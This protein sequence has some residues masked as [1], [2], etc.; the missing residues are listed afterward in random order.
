MYHLIYFRF[1][2]FM[3]G[4]EVGSLEVSYIGGKSYW[5]RKPLILDYAE[6]FCYVSY[7]I[8]KV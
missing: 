4:A 7:V 3:H 2:Y 6:I 1:W 8:T 5:K